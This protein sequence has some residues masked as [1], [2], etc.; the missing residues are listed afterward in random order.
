[1]EH[2]PGHLIE[3]E[4]AMSAKQSQTFMPFL[5]LITELC[6]RARVPWDDARDIKVNPS[7]STDIWRIEVEYTREETNRR[8]TAPVDTSLEVDIG[9]IPAKASLPT[10]ASGPSSTFAPSSS[11]QGETSEVTASKAKVADMRKDVDYLKSTDFTSLLE[12][13]DDVDAPETSEV[14]LAT[15]RDVHRDDTSVDESDVETD[16]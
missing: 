3:Q 5:V 7:S 1:M 9:S 14:S 10:L 6:R 4:M 11:L 13:A 8:R 15:T 12:A 16:K 2:Q